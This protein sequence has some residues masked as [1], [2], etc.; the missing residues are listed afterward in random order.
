VGTTTQ[1]PKFS[2]HD[3]AQIWD[4]ALRNNV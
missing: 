2:V 1:E 3:S 4:M